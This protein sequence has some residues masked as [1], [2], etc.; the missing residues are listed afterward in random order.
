MIGASILLGIAVAQGVAI[1]EGL[2]RAVGV[3]ARAVVIVHGGLGAGGGTLQVSIIHQLLGEV[4][5]Q[6]ITMGI[7][8][9]GAVGVA[10]RAV[11]VVHGGFGAGS[12]GLQVGIIH[13][14]LGKVVAQGITIG[15]GIRGAVLIAARAAVVVYGG[16][17]AGGSSL[18]VGIVHDLL[19]EVVT[20]GQAHGE[21]LIGV[22]VVAANTG[23]VVHRGLGAGGGGLHAI[24]T[25][26]HF[27]VD[28]AQGFLQ[29]ALVAVVSLG[30]I[31]LA[32]VIG[33]EL[34]AV[35]AVP[36][37]IVA[38]LD[39]VGVLSLGLSD[40]HMVI[41]VLIRQL[42]V[43]GGALRLGYAGGFVAGV[44]LVGALLGAAVVLADLP[45]LGG[46][47]LIGLAGEVVAQSVQQEAGI[48]VVSDGG[49]QL[50]VLVGIVV[51]AVGAVPIGIVAAHF[52]GGSHGLRLFSVLMGQ[53]R[54]V[55]GAGVVIQS[56]VAVLEILLAVGAVVISLVARS[57][58]GGSLVSGGSDLALGVVVGIEL[59]ILGMAGGTH[60]L[61][62]AGG[63]GVGHVVSTLLGGA[64]G[65]GAVAPV[66]GVIV[67]PRA[68]DVIGGVLD[69]ELPAIGRKAIGGLE[70]AV[71]GDDQIHL[72]GAG[73]GGTCHHLAVLL[74]H[75]GGLAAAQSVGAVQGDAR[76]FGVAVPNQVGGSGE[77]EVR[78][79]GR[80]L[81][82]DPGEGVA[83]GGGAPLVSILFQLHSH[84]V[85]A[86]VGG[87][88][89]ALHG[90]ALVADGQGVLF[91]GIGVA[92]AGCGE[93]DGLQILGHGHFGS[94]GGVGDI[95]GLDADIVG[96]IAAHGGGA[97]GAV[98][99]G[100]AVSG[101]LHGGL[102]AADRAVGGRPAGG[103]HAGE[104]GG[105]GRGI[106]GGGIVQDQ[107]HV[108]GGR[109]GDGEL[110]EAV[111]GDGD[112]VLGQIGRIVLG[113]V[114]AVCGGDGH[115]RNGA[116]LQNRLLQVAGGGHVLARGDGDGAGLG[117]DEKLV[118]VG[119][120]L[121]LIAL[122][123]GEI[124]PVA[125]VAGDV[126][127][128]D[129]AAVLQ[130]LIPGGDTDGGACGE[131][132]DSGELF[133]RSQEQVVV[134][135][136]E[137]V[138]GDVHLAGQG[139]DPVLLRIGVDSG[140]NAA[141]ILGGGVAGDGGI[142]HPERAVCV[143]AAAQYRGIIGDGGVLDGSGLPAYDSI[144]SRVINGVGQAKEQAAAGIGGG[145]A[146]DG[147]AINGE[148][149][150][151]RVQAAAIGG[152]VAGDGAAVDGDGGVFAVHAATTANVVGAGVI[153]LG[154]VTGDDTIVHNEGTAGHID[155]A[156]SAGVSRTL[157][158]GAAVH[159]EGAVLSHMHAAAVA[160]GSGAGGTGSGIELGDA[161]APQGEGS[162]CGHLHTLVA[163][164]VGELAGLLRRAVGDGGVDSIAYC[165]TGAIVITSG[166]VGVAVE[167]EVA[168]AHRGPG[169]TGVV[170]TILQQVIVALGQ[171]IEG[172][173]ADPLD[174]C[175][176]V[177]AAVGGVFPGAAD[178]VGVVIAPVPKLQAGVV[179]I[180][181]GRRQV[182]A[183]A[184]RGGAQGVA[185]SVIREEATIRFGS[186]LYGQS[187]DI[188]GGNAHPAAGA[189]VAVCIHKDAPGLGAVQVDIVFHAICG[190]I[191]DN[192]L[193]AEYGGLITAA[194]GQEDAAAS[195][196]GGVAGDSAVGDLH[197][198]APQPQSAAAR[199][200]RRVAGEDAAGD[201][202]AALVSAVDSA[203][204]VLVAG[205]AVAGEGAAGYGDAGSFIPIIVVGVDGS[206]PVLLKGAVRHRGG[207]AVDIQRGAAVFGKD[208]VLQNNG[209]TALGV[210]DIALRLPGSHAVQGQLGVGVIGDGIAG[211]AGEIAGVGAGMLAVGDGEGAVVY[212]V[213]SGILMAVQADINSGVSGNGE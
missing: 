129:G 36:V 197:I 49:I 35:A 140:V 23:V 43:A 128:A 144:A 131:A 7:G 175:V 28:M 105:S 164:G 84:G 196:A 165:D 48:T 113:E 178:T 5:A 54:D 34:A 41:G 64:A 52:A 33:E 83:L 15:I 209:G 155:A 94:L 74:I 30:G 141:A 138:A 112:A 186:A 39:A 11:V 190:V 148:F 162:V 142:A 203:A 87:L 55:K 205:G 157:R 171:V 199:V 79:L 25:H 212:D 208:A 154:A 161:A 103:R 61:G 130:G 195:P 156:S 134:C 189:E 169:R 46:A 145:I 21:C 116:V 207:S 108:R 132:G 29:E 13:D 26:D 147:G 206:A 12:S 47:G 78:G 151:T 163:V 72:V 126:D 66:L 82:D 119:I 181:V 194:I 68:I 179:I 45:V 18:P 81:G 107:G 115:I 70:V 204:A 191:L 19:G 75:Q 193:T 67:L 192:D 2:V 104:T 91:T 38:G 187:G 182:G 101:P 201:G 180:G 150:G 200:R 17:G 37:G 114:I 123:A 149:A 62:D 40:V 160:A 31:H 198:L 27:F 1:G 172:G 135:F 95:R 59:A 14:L 136:A 93:V 65:H 211:A 120:Q 42:V 121:H 111:A 69:G 99:P 210:D 183:R 22:V 202:G 50:A 188:V 139:V 92:E 117:D 90:V 185:A 53:S 60:S 80:S 176:L 97:V 170:I 16:L 56:L 77:G 102:G 4:V 71:A 184:V 159:G 96:T 98:G 143:Y 213:G 177:V 153:G 86:R 100:L 127:G 20:Q 6:G 173:N 125:R 122:I 9:L 76:G 44:G 3:A 166:G 158:D 8:I 174:L 73:I 58:A 10:A 168:V 109:A 32:V 137:L 146:G 152:L 24:S 133:T 110:G 89:D 167:A 85:G 118:L 51:A 106:L 63:G 124:I 88:G 57:A